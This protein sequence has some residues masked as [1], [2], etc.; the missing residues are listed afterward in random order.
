MNEVKQRIAIADRCPEMWQDR[1]F[2]W[3][4]TGFLVHPYHETIID[5]LKDTNIIHEALKKL[6]TSRSSQ[7]AFEYHLRSIIGKSDI[8]G[9]DLVTATATQQA[10]ALLKA[11]V[12]SE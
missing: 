3:T 11:L 10:E 2:V 8:N 4:N 1:G 7:L 9:Y 12:P 6:L 5:P